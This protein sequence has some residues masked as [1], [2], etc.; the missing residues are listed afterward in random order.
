M[1]VETVSVI[2]DVFREMAFFCAFVWPLQLQLQLP[3]GDLPRDITSEDATHKE[4]R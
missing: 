2:Y 1:R 3:R 4:H